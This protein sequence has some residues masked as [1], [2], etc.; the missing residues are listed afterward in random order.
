MLSF[1]TIMGI[2]SRWVKSILYKILLANLLVHIIE[3]RN[4]K[5]GMSKEDFDKL[6]EDEQ[7]YF[8]RVMRIARVAVEANRRVGNSKEKIKKATSDSMKFK[9]PGAV[10]K[11]NMEAVNNTGGVYNFRERELANE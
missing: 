4:G 8:K 7:E 2:L 9:M 6:L 1:L 5:L 11:E 3:R 10:L